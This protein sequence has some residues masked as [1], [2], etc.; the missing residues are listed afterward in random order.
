MYALIHVENRYT[1]VFFV[2]LWLGLLYSLHTTIHR[3]Q[4]IAA[5]VMLG[6]AISL[7]LPVANSGRTP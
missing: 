7:M 2:L 4:Q 6:I 5:G 1:G 3:A